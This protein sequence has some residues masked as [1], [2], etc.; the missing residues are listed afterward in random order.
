MRGTVAIL[1]LGAA[2]V[3]ASCATAAVRCP[4]GDITCERVR[5]R[6]EVARGH[7]GEAEG[8]EVADARMEVTRIGSPAVPW[9]VRALDDEEPSV[10]AFAARSL[11]EMGHTDDVERWCQGST[12]NTD[13]FCGSGRR[14][15]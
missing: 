3:A 2:V 10:A 14:R 5:A 8:G 7:A 4:G 13:I 1:A 15:H 9:L 11:M 6:I 12:P